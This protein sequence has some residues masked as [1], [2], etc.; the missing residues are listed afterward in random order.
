[1]VLW[2]PWT[3]CGATLL[4]ALIIF[5]LI[6]LMMGM[7]PS[8]VWVCLPC[9]DEWSLACGFGGLR[10]CGLGVLWTG[11]W[12]NYYDLYF[13]NLELEYLFQLLSCDLLLK[14]IIFLYPFSPLLVW[15][16][17]AHNSICNSNFVHCFSNLSLLITAWFCN[18]LKCIEHVVFFQS[19]AMWPPFVQS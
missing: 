4:C 1:M 15:I 3:L 7:M 16:V 9:T 14:V 13:I 5:S 10:A 12:L 2:P 6:F 18:L 11:V 19:Q 8:W 17:K